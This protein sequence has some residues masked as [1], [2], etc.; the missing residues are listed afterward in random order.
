MSH[1]GSMKVH[2]HCLSGR[3]RKELRDVLL[4]DLF[5]WMGRANMPFAIGKSQHKLCGRA[6]LC[7]NHSGC[8]RDLFYPIN[9]NSNLGPRKAR[10]GWG[11]VYPPLRPASD[12]NKDK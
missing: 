12:L 11:R 2:Q 3:K 9:T 10:E 4:D 6:L 5:M 8:D 7:R 1:L